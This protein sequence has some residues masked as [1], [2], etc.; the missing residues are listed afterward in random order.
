MWEYNYTDEL[1]HYGVKGMKWGRRKGIRST[2]KSKRPI[3]STSWDR[4][5]PS[6]DSQILVGEK[7][8]TKAKSELTPEQKKAR[9]KK[10]A[11]G[12]AIAGGTL[13]AYGALKIAAAASMVKGGQ[14]AVSV[15]MEKY[16]SF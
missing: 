13:A 15:M 16:G 11:I 7:K 1:Y 9:N 12:A 2:Q 3:G 10:I 4:P 8:Y 6:K 14:R 5:S